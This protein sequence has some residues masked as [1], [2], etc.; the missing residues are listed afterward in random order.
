MSTG[1]LIFFITW[2]GVG[3]AIAVLAYKEG[4]RDGTDEGYASGLKLGKAKG[5]LEYYEA[6]Q[7]RDKARR[8]RIGRFRAKS[9][10]PAIVCDNGGRHV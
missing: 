9:Q 3:A 10:K 7:A 2:F 8:D 1:Y 5:W 4:K 6:E